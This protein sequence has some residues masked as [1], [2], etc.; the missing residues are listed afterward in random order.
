MATRSVKLHCTAQFYSNHGSYK[1]KGKENLW[2]TCIWTRYDGATCTIVAKDNWSTDIVQCDSS[3]GIANLRG[4]N[5]WD[6]S[7]VIPS[8]KIKDGGNWTCKMEKCHDQGCIH[9]DSG[10]CFGEDTFYLQV[11]IL[12]KFHD[13]TSCLNFIED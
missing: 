4:G 7:I 8:V 2:K 3:L 13:N 10:I 5:R 11:K 9:K 6:C 12:M 1:N